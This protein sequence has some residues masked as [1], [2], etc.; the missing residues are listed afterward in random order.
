MIKLI[1]SDMDGTFLN[2]DSKFN[3]EYFKKIHQDMKRMYI[4]FAACTGLLLQKQHGSIF[5]T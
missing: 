5:R 1:I 2:S 4:T 3:Q